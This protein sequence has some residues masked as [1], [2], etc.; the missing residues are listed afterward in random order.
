MSAL[1]IRGMCGSVAVSLGMSFTT[2]PASPGTA[3]G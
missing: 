1:S 3:H 2:A